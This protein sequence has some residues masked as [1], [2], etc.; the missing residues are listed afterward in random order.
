MISYR[1]AD[2]RRRRLNSTNFSLSRCLLLSFV[3][4][5]IL[6][7]AWGVV[8]AQSQ[9]PEAEQTD[10]V[11]G[12]VVNTVTKAPI[13]RALVYSSDNR[14]ATLTDGEGHCEFTVPRG[15]Q[16]GAKRRRQKDFFTSAW[17]YRCPPVLQKGSPSCLYRSKL[18]EAGHRNPG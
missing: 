1:M 11:R 2:R 17:S 7:A 12:T 10:T 13:A 6:F 8:T 15:S 14:Y 4:V 5:L 9:E 18:D 3:T 16:D